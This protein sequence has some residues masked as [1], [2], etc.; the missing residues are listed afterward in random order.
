MKNCKVEENTTGNQH[1][2]KVVVDVYRQDPE[3]DGASAIVTMQGYV[4]AK[5]K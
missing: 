4:Y 1:I 2:K 5:E 3:A